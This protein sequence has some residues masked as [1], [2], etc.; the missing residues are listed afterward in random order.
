M[1]ALYRFVLLLKGDGQ[2][3]GKIMLD[4]FG[5]CALELA[6]L[7]SNKSCLAFAMKKLRERCLSPETTGSAA[8]D[9]S[10]ATPIFAKHFSLIPEPGRSALALIYLKFFPARDTAALLNMNIED[11]SRA[12]ENARVYLRRTQTDFTPLSSEL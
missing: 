8:C 7:R 11:F 9:G 5:E 12:L 2:S 10:D 1:L 6:Q 3:A 4:V